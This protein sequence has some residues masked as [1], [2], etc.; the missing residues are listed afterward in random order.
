MKLSEIVRIDER[1]RIVIPKTIRE[2]LGL[3]QG[4]YL[5]VSTDIKSNEIRVVP[6]AD[7][8]TKT[9][10]MLITM[11]D[12][13]GSLARIANVL[14]N[15]G[16]DLLLGESRIIKRK[17]VAKW[18]IIADLTNC[19]ESLERIKDMLIKEGGAEEVEFGKS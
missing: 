16:I 12:F 6:F 4:M 15:L 14:A 1:Y 8:G 19:E 3:V 18:T 9:V 7:P 17:K 5:L 11:G 10:E 13:P 2:S